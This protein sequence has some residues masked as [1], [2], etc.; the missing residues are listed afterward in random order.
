MPGCR[1]EVGSLPRS[2]FLVPLGQLPE[3]TAE[4][5][6][7][8]LGRGR[9]LLGLEREYVRQLFSVNRYKRVK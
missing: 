7:G 4:A 9:L 8:G 6:V 3:E 5:G 1:G 2:L